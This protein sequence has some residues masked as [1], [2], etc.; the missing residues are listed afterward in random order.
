MTF[1]V[2]PED[3]LALMVIPSMATNIWQAIYGRTS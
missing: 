1:A 3:A 2:Q